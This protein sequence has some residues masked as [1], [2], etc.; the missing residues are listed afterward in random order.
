MKDTKLSDI[1]IYTT[2]LDELQTRLMAAGYKQFKFHT[3]KHDYLLPLS[4]QD[5]RMLE[6]AR[7]A[8]RDKNA[9]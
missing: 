7:K 8:W 9:H 3:G 4:E 6:M 2:D 1:N 5:R